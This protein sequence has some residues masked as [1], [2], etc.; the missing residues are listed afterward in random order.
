MTDPANP[1]A[2][3]PEAIAAAWVRLRPNPL[4]PEPCQTLVEAYAAAG[5]VPQQAYASGQR[6]RLGAA[7]A[8]AAALEPASIAGPNP[9]TAEHHL[10]HPRSA[11]AQAWAQTLDGW[12]ARCP[13]D[14]LSWL[15]RARL[16]DGTSTATATTPA[17]S[18]VPA[19]PDPLQ[20]AETLEPI[21]GESRHWLGLWRLNGGDASGAVDALPPPG[22][23]PATASGPSGSPRSSAA[24]PPKTAATSTAWR[25]AT[26]ARAGSPP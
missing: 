13:G 6:R 1:S 3:P 17:A 22:E 21:A 5:H 2:P 15:Y 16:A 8:S 25:C 18:D 20:Q 23:P 19:A 10:L 24:W 26:A 11:A 7:S 9:S 4:A 12:L 14:W